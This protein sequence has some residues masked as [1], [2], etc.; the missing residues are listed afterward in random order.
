M[1]CCTG[2]S[3]SGY[4]CRVASGRRRGERR[5]RLWRA[6]HAALPLRASRGQAMTDTVGRCRS[7]LARTRVP[8]RDVVPSVEA[9][10]Q[11]SSLKTSG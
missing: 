2:R 4:R 3:R 11:S 8:L 7:K 5:L 1:R 9:G 10:G 6:S